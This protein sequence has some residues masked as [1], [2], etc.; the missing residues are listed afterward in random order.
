[1]GCIVRFLYTF[2]L[3]LALP[4]IFLRLLWKSRRS[5]AYRKRMAERLGIYPFKLEQ[6]VWVHAV[7]V[8]E[9][10]AAIPLIKAL[11]THFAPLP[12]VVTTMTPTG[13]QRVKAMLGDSVIHAYL[14]YDF[15]FAVAGFLRAAKP[16]VAVMM[17]TE[18]WPNLLAACHKRHIP[19]CVVNA[20]LS[21]KSAQGYQKIAPL[22]RDMLRRITVIAAHG[23]ADAKRFI[24]LGATN[25]QLLITG[26]LKFDLEIPHDL[27]E[28]SRQLR[29]ELGNERFIWVAASTHEG[30]EEQIL[31]AHKMLRKINNKAL[32][33]LVPRHPERF[34]AIAK[35]SA[36]SFVTARRSLQQ[37]C[38][39]DT[40]VYVGD[41]M[42][43]LL[44]MYAVSDVAFV[45]GS[46]I[47]RGGHN[48]LEPAAL[49]KPVISGTQLF[50]F[51]E[52]SELFAAANALK[53]V[54][55]AHALAAA[56]IA[57]MEQPGERKAM[58]MRAMQV[59]AENRGALQKQFD[60]IVKAAL[61]S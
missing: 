47:E 61:S 5:S 29:N 33:V 27:I 23:E 51:A 38:T 17:E 34:D 60:V 19:V 26:N 9:T 52:I 46:L 42:G 13:A 10:L 50:N 59:V 15:P 16:K 12:I 53:K 6:C 8:G 57:L 18:L 28:K 56:L 22:T 1:M 35:M 44:L 43:E 55:D 31:A 21:E 30:E 37:T 40:A 3:L 14:P 4:Y 48:L 45:G 2:L 36:Q 20:R 11:Q 7:S 58:G 24:A 41:T 32:L 39:Q 25:N 54:T 49:G